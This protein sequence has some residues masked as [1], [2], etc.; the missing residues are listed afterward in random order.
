MELKITRIGNSMGLILPRELLNR[1]DLDRGDA[2]FVTQTPTGF[3]ITPFDP[4]FA[5]QM[6]AARE[7][8]RKRRNVVNEL[9]RNTP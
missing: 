4:V 1:L 7:I 2:L 8:L 9:D 3:V 6:E 5:E